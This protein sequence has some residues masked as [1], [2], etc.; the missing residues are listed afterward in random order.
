MN[1][2]N[3]SAVNGTDEAGS[4]TRTEMSATISKQ[5]DTYDA[6]VFALNSLLENFYLD[7][8]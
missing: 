4:W 5:Y 2:D 3:G 8:S 1:Y 7:R 6:A